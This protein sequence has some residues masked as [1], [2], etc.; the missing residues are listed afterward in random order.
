MHSLVDQSLT[1]TRVAYGGHLLASKGQPTRVLRAY[2]S[3]VVGIKHLDGREHGTNIDHLDQRLDMPRAGRRS[4]GTRVTFAQMATYMSKP[5][6]DRPCGLSEWRTCK[7]VCVDFGRT[8]A[9]QRADPVPS[10][11]PRGGGAR[12]VRELFRCP[13]NW[14]R[15]QAEGLLHQELRIMPSGHVRAA[16]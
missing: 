15:A 12:G 14:C 10:D 11:G 9:A 7:H 6:V 13:T 1:S 5:H 16:R 8:S 4:T 3:H 2:H